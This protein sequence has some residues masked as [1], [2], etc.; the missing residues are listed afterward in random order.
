MRS[1][2]IDWTSTV[3]VPHSRTVMAE[4]VPIVSIN[5]PV[6]NGLRN[7]RSIAPSNT[8]ASRAA[9]YREM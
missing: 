8:V 3:L 2:V 4:S 1:P 7:C 6:S 5:T 9:G